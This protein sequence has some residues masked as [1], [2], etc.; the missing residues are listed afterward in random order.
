MEAQAI[1]ATLGGVFTL[2]GAVLI[3]LGCR[4]EKKIVND[5]AQRPDARKFITRF[6]PRLE[7]G[8]PKVGGLI[9]LVIGVV[10]LVL[11]LFV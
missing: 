7:A 11:A 8:G 9:A 3:I 1:V 10:L 6:P 5:I 2:L 4:E